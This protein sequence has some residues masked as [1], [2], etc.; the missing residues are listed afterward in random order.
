[1]DDAHEDHGPEQLAGPH[2]PSLD[3]WALQQSLL[4]A[5]T[6][7]DFLD[8]FTK[9]A[10]AAT[11]HHCSITARR[12]DKRSPY[13][14]ASSD[15]FTLQLDELQYAQGNGPC[16]D[17]L[18]TV[19]PVIVTDMATE[20]RYDSYPAHAV[21]VGAR[22]SMSYPLTTGELTIGVLNLYAEQ[23]LSPNLELRTRVQALADNAAGALALAQRLAD[24]HDLISNLKTALESRST[25]D[26]AIGIIM[27]EQRC[28]PPTAFDLLIAASQ[29]RNIKLRDL[30]A[31][32]ISGVQRQ[33]P[34]PGPGRY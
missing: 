12:S 30:A 8:Q 31:R 10:A 21:D 7:E 11:R 23:P 27:A 22:S 29:N 25:I 17:A 9:Q 15:D 28:D 13:T 6:V 3:W 20:T 5:D 19:S 14:V 18:D 34:R 16:L 4:A 2:E 33:T 24:Q 32:M 26:Q 1:M